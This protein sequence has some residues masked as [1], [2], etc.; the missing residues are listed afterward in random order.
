MTFKLAFPSLKKKVKFS[1]LVSFTLTPIVSIKLWKDSRAFETTKL[2]EI[3]GL[4]T[5]EKL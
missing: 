1:K 4:N 3:V 5:I 2:S